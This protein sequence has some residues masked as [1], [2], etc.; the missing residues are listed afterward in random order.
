MPNTRELLRLNVG[1]IVHQNVGYS[2]EFPFDFESIHL[3]PDLDLQK[4][5][6]TARITR[7]T[8]GLL[9]QFKMRAFINA[10]CV[11]CL[12]GCLQLLE[13]DFTELYAFNQNS[14]TESGLI[15]P[16]NGKINLEPLIREE[17]LLAIPISPLC[18]TDCKGLCPI[19]GEN[20]NEHQ[21]THADDVIDHRLD[22]L[23]SITD[24]TQDSF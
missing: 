10:D 12:T 21:C 2:R 18:R 14:I 17:F 16:E 24:K 3:A 5:S 22:V 23:I 7:A 20:L 1:F 4:F 13:I 6:G 19:C 11:R 9:T 15:V 8:Q